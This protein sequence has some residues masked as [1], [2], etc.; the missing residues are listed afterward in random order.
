MT[1]KIHKLYNDN[2]VQK[3]PIQPIIYNTGTATYHLAKYLPKL[4]STPSIAEYTVS[5]TKNFVQ[6]IRTTKVPT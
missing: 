3:L 5:S 6:N 4:I 1:V 2:N